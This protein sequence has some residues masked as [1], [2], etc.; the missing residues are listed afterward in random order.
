MKYPFSLSQF[1]LAVVV[2]A[3]LLPGAAWAQ[4]ERTHANEAET[5]NDANNSAESNEPTGTPFLDSAARV[6]LGEIELGKL[7]EQK[8]DNPAVRD[9]GKRMVEDHT[10]LESQL[11]AD[12]KTEGV[13]LPSQP[14]TDT[15]DLRRQ[16]ANESGTKFDD[17]YIQHMLSGHKQAINNFEN[18]IEH[19][20]NPTY[21]SYAEAA[22]PVIQDHIRIAEDVAGKMQLSGK[23]GLESPNKAINAPA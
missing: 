11:Q 16:L 13:T 7:A 9:Y 20:S 2:T 17:V 14:G 19:G 4:N 5:A 3:L 8:G 22:L 18:E 21:K 6:N 23:A 10:K 1:S 12:A 15:A